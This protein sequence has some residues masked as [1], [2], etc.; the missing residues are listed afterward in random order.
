[1]VNL[2]RIM[3][4]AP[5]S[6]H[7][8]TTLTLG[9]IAALARTRQVSAHKVGPD[10][11]DP[12]YHTLAA[13]RPGRNLDPVLCGEHRI[14]PLLLRG[15]QHPTPADIAV[16]EG[17]MGL[18]DG[19]LG[20]RGEGSSAHV[21]ALTAT[22]I[23]LCVD[24]S[25]TAR[26]LGALVHGITAWR[27]D[28]QVAGVV[29]NKVG[30]PRHE[31]E[32]RAAIEET[33]PVLGV[34]PRDAA[35]DIPS[36][37]LGL[38]PAAERDQAE[39]VVARLGEWVRRHVDVE[40]IA[41]LAATAPPLEA[42]AWDPQQEVR[43]RSHRRPVVAVAA[44]RAFT[45]RY[46]ETAELL[47]AGGCD[48]VEFDPLSDRT[49]PPGTAGLYLGGGFPEVFA[50]ELA[51]NVALLRDVAAQIAA[52][53]PTV[54]ECA[55]LLYL[56]RSL[57]GAPM[58]GALPATGAMHPRLKLGYR[59]A[60]AAS[61]TLLARR[62]EVVWGHEF[63]RTRV[64]ADAA[65]ANA[66]VW[67]GQ[68]D[69]VALG[70]V[71]ASYLHTHWAG[72]PHLAQ[73]FVDAV[74]AYQPQSTTPP[75]ATRRS[76]AVD[77]LH[78]G[79]V[80]ARAGGLDVAVNTFPGGPPAFLTRAL[81][82]ADPTR[83]PDQE[84]ARNLLATYHGLAPET[85]LLTAGAAEAFGLVARGA[86]L[87]RALVLHPQF[88]EPEVA[89]RAAGV[90]VHRH[91]LPPGFE[92]DPGHIAALARAHACDAVVI[93]NPTNPTGRLHRRTDL[94]AL[95]D[96]GLRVVVDEAFINAIPGEPETLL[97][98]PGVIVIRSLTKLWSIPGVRVGWI[99]ADPDVVVSLSAQQPSWSVSAAGVAAVLATCTDD[100]R[101]EQERRQLAWQ[102]MKD[103]LL[104]RLQTSDIDHLE[105]SAAPFVL[106]NTGLDDAAAALA[107]S[108]VAA[109]R[110][111][112]FP[113]LDD[114]WV[115]I[116]ARD[117]HTNRTVV[118]ALLRGTAP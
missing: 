18:F 31:A 104:A 40:G 73:R 21:A 105:E 52:G 12:G 27:S 38:V 67:E 92:L 111:G 117:P 49:L 36:R 10:Y 17:V 71:H 78:H 102:I 60:T 51:S 96:A 30:S 109:R 59:Q 7:G 85:V 91:V 23:L 46:T 22:P 54:A 115:R 48:V 56:S 74:H 39:R 20:S 65:T 62:G 106:V 95:R 70:H 77:L 108:G 4:A 76:A 80:D 34:L 41:Q 5:A 3:V 53:L 107:S 47:E 90:P 61:D 42:G 32:A 19:R 43:A 79:D 101:A 113:G 55:G 24:A 99:Q 28:I 88:T 16:V 14:V 45:F 82:A 6:G 26:T 35:L 64:V 98:Q 116:A 100:A 84:P 2:P 94:L 33:V 89:L 25:H 87:Q 58:V 81:L 63:H 75:P 72:H 44:G 103:D 68:G 66:W 13:G 93:G 9:L 69:G 97:N 1:M 86:G 83:Y 57:D 50:V 8:K 37:H 15:A 112:T 118:E 29:L 11:I 110:A 114:G